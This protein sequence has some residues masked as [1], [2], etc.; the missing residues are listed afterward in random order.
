MD[1]PETRLIVYGSLAPGG[2]NTILLAGLVGEWYRCSIR[3]HLGAYRGFNSFR[4][5]PQGPEHPAWLLESAELPQIIHDLDDF[6][7]E[8]YQRCVIPA[9]VRGR[10]VMA[11]IY[12][13]KYVD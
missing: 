1:N 9:Q 13:G 11:Q 5:D 4:Y 12:A 8:E 10:W 6:E 3:G 2:A 7:G